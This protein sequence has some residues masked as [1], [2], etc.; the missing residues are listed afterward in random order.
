MDSSLRTSSGTPSSMPKSTGGGAA[1][2]SLGTTGSGSTKRRS[3][4]TR[5]IEPSERSLAGLTRRCSSLRKSQS[6]RGE[7]CCGRRWLGT[8]GESAASICL[9]KSA[10]SRQSFMPSA[11]SL[12]CTSCRC[13]RSARSSVVGRTGSHSRTFSSLLATGSTLLASLRLSSCHS[14]ARVASRSSALGLLLSSSARLSRSKYSESLI[15]RSLTSSQHC[16][17]T[18]RKARAHAHRSSA[19]FHRPCC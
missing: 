14:A 8:S 10:G 3:A 11:M 5:A 1:S 2:F 18:I 4:E 17:T 7:T 16:V 15:V 6:T 19:W 13:F 12:S 9:S